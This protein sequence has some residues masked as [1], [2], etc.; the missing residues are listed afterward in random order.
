MRR[1]GSS[2]HL[3]VAAGQVVQQ[4][5]Q[6]T[7]HEQEHPH[8]QH[9]RRE[10]LQRADLDDVL[11]RSR[12]VR[13]GGLAQQQREEAAREGEQQPADGEF[14][15]VPQH[16]Q[17]RLRLGAAQRDVD[18]RDHQR[19][20]HARAEPVA[21]LRVAL[22][23]QRGRDHQHR[24]EQH[25]RDDPNHGV[26]PLPLPPAHHSLPRRS[27]AT[28][29]MTATSSTVISTR[30]SRPRK[31]A[32]ITVTTSPPC[33]AGVRR[34][35]SDATV[36]AAGWDRK[37]HTVANTARPA[38]A[39]ATTSRRRFRTRSASSRSR[40]GC[41]AGNRANAARNTSVSMVSTTTATNATSGAPTSAYTAARANP[42][43]ESTNTIVNRSRARAITN[44]TT[45]T[46][47]SSVNTSQSRPATG[48]VV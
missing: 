7:D 5:G 12:A 26:R 38:T 42:I 8:V 16:R 23:D 9:E 47:P 2:P 3:V 27:N 33:A 35:R 46:N 10:Q 14:R 6:D 30:V 32:T 13:H 15:R 11:S 39:P 1:R 45:T 21:D 19:Y 4:H 31:S 25:P 24:A 22:R 36:L 34:M 44:A 37:P 20:R 29:P 18:Q 28:T 17:C 48:P 43:T 41:S 40:S